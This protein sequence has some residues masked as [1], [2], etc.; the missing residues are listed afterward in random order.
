MGRVGGVGVAGVHGVGPRS[1]DRV[2]PSAADPP[3]AVRGQ[4]SA[5]LRSARGRVPNLAS[6]T[7][8]AALR[9][10]PGDW[11]A[12]WGPPV[13]AA[14]T[15]TD[16]ARHAGGCYR[17]ANFALVGQTAGWG[18]S[19]RSYVHHGRVK[20]VWVR[21]L[22]R[23]ARVLL[24]GVFDHP[25]FT[26]H[27]RRIPIIDCNR[28]D[29]E[30]DAGLLARLEALPEHRHA[31]GIRH[32]VASII[33]VAVVATMSGAK[34]YRGIGEAAADLPQDVLARLGCRFHPVRRCY[35]APSENTIRTNL[36]SIDGDGLDTVVGAWVTDQDLAARIAATGDQT[37]PDLVAIA[38]DGKW[39]RGTSTRADRQVKLFAGLV[40][41][42]GAVIAQT[43]VGEGTTENRA[44]GPL[45]GQLGDLDA[46]VITADAAHTNAENARHVV[47]DL[48]HRWR[49]AAPAPADLFPHA[50]QIVR[51]TRERCTL[52]DELI[53]TETA[54]YITSLPARLASP[55]Q[56]DR[57]VRGHWGIENRVHYVRDVTYDEDRSQA[58]TGNGPRVLATCRNLAISVL[59]LHG[60]T[61]IAKA[62]R[63]IARNATRALTIL[64]L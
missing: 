5:I 43:Q 62:L 36:Q 7:L 49:A 52:D 56:L 51:V 10:L 54:F 32:S 13:V 29:F 4:Q 3:V 44:F 58:Y 34:S 18:R 64:G 59:R 55:E 9:S 1:L 60:H 30:S 53:S 46:K 15:F 41:H 2:V 12:L 50:E 24:A 63:H 35:I 37:K 25:V 38:V 33:A 39:L 45:L 11:E 8:A 42:N 28:L 20:A 14:E 61:N 27:P 16:P 40:H 47:D 48:D 31:R 22:R 21:E 19:N 17:A 57:L 26:G 23:Q 6:A